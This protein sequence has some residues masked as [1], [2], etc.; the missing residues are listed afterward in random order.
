[1]SGVKVFVGGIL[2]DSEK[3][4]IMLVWE[5][6]ADRRL[7]GAHVSNM[8]Q[9]DGVRFY[10]SFPGNSLDEKGFQKM[11]AEAESCLAIVKVN[12]ITDRIT[13][14][15]KQREI[16]EILDATNVRCQLPP[17]IISKNPTC[18]SPNIKHA[19][20]VRDDEEPDAIIKGGRP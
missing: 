8:T 16:K 3:V 4:P 1:M 15:Q 12:N 6:D 20:Q 11:C 10:A 19:L 13:E 14:D 17:K 2:Y 7:T 9:K 5:N 18:D